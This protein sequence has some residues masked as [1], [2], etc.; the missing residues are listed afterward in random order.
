M[1]VNVLRK[2]LKD[3]GIPQRW[4]LINEGIRSDTNILEKYSGQWQYYYYDEKGNTRD[5][6]H[7][8]SEA[9]ACQYLY[10]ILKEEYDFFYK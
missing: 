4:Y 10:D 6:R 2:R 8:T 1:D 7:F 3:E 5:L 9:E